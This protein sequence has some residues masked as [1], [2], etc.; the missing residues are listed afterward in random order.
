MPRSLLLIGWPKYFFDFSNFKITGRNPDRTFK[1]KPDTDQGNR[2]FADDCD[3][4]CF[5]AD[6]REK[7]MEAGLQAINKL[8]LSVIGQPRENLVTLKTPITEVCLFSFHLIK[9][10][11]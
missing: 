3:R 10:L 11:I 9:V 5:P 8:L 4:R 6:Q 2:F 7:T 1:D